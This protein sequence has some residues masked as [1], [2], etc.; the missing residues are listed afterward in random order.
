MLGV[1]DSLQL[2]VGF[3]NAGDLPIQTQP[4]PTPGR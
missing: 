3:D 4:I 1:T 2:G